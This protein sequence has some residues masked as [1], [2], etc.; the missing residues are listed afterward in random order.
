M[1]SRSAKRLNKALADLPKETKHE[2][3][4]DLPK[5]TKHEILAEIPNDKEMKAFLKKVPLF[6]K[7]AE[8]MS[9]SKPESRPWHMSTQLRSLELSMESCFHVGLGL[10]PVH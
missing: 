9:K 5:E 3:L 7:A 8:S 1:K 6:K 2:I 10:Q 4:A